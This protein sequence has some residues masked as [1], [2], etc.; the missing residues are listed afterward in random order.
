VPAA[1]AAFGPF[2]DVLNNWFIRRSRERFWSD[3]QSDDKQ[4]AYDV[5]YTVLVTMTRTL[6]PLLPYVTDHIHRALCDGR[7]VH[8]EDW[9][10]ADSFVRDEAV[11]ARMDMARDV[12]SA[13][14]S[15]RTAKN[16]RVRLPLRELTVAHA[17][18]EKVAPLI[19]VIAEEVNVKEVRLT[20]DPDQFGRTV[21]AVDPRIG[22]RLGK[23]MKDVMA[24]S[25]KGEWTAGE[26][27]QVSVGGQVIGA[28]EYELRFEPAK[29]V[30]AAAFSGAS[31]VVVLDTAVDEALEREGMARDFI[32]QVQ[33]ARK[34]AGL[35]VADRISLTVRADG[36]AEAALSAHR[37]MIMGE[38]LAISMDVGGQAPGGFTQ[39][40]ELGAQSVELGIEKAA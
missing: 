26:D 34:E 27:G 32:R 35:H 23:A 29:G 1:C 7:S 25:R 20:G 18:S 2:S 13:A 38:V 30:D 21:L 37:E 19:G 12:C 4:A 33:T 40:A 39:A 22:K 16:L 36:A 3:Q 24:A 17:E 5:L 31:G 14:L 6:A 11:I 28:D 10:D 15:L 8:L 9:P